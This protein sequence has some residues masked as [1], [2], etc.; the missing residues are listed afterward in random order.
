MIVET[1]KTC[2]YSLLQK[3]GGTLY[4]ETFLFDHQYLIKLLSSLIK[5]ISFH[6]RAVTLTFT[7]IT[8]LEYASAFA[9]TKFQCDINN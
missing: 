2:E 3:D 6:H 7:V 5:D 9:N 1:V 4:D 8:I